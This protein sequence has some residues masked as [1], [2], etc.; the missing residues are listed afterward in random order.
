LRQWTARAQ[1]VD[2][3]S[4]T[5]AASGSRRTFLVISLAGLAAV[6][7]IIL[8]VRAGRAAALLATMKSEFVSTVTHELKTPLASIRLVSETLARRRFESSDKVSE[9]AGLLLN[10]VT[11]LTRTVNNLLTFSRI[12][13]VNRFY[14]FEPVDPGTLLEEALEIFHSQLKEQNFDVV[15]DIPAPLPTVRVDR[16]AILQ[17][18]EN[19][20]DNAIRY[21]NGTRSLTVSASGSATEVRMKIADKGQGIPPNELPRVFD[22]FFRGRD[23]SS[24]GSG[25]GLAIVQRIVKDHHGEVRLDSVVGGGTVAEV[26]L[27]VSERSDGA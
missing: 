22:K 27:P 26:I 21:S 3:Q 4:S 17:V 14:S 11:R 12:E 18:L 2:D 6:V 16:T 9:Y 8:T 19:L 13:D 5:A 25:L 24:S 1:A 7:A 15:V 10:D 23:S 20:M